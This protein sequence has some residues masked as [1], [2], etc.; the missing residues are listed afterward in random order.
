VSERSRWARVAL[1]AALV[2]LVALTSLGAYAIWRLRTDLRDALARA[3][4]GD[5]RIA[6]LQQLVQ[7]ESRD[8]QQMVQRLTAEALTSSTRAER[9]ANVLAASDSRAFP[10]RGQRAAAAA[11]GQVLFSPTRGIALTA[12]KLPATSSNDVYQIWLVTSRGSIG[13]GFVSPDAQGRVAAAFETP[14]DL[15]GN[16]TGF[17]LSLEPAGGSRTPTGPI[18]LAS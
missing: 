17:M 5:A 12:S 6:Q 10:L 8:T 11:E 15:A 2:V 1:V 7:R 4:S 16:V 3:T 13:L 9:L 18:V 14:P